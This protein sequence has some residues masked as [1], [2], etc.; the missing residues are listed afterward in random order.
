[1]KWCVMAAALMLATG[2]S[3][4]DLSPFFPILITQTSEA[5][6]TPPGQYN[7]IAKPSELARS[8][9]SDVT[10]LS[11]SPPGSNTIS[12]EIVAKNYFSKFRHQK[13]DGD[14][15]SVELLVSTKRAPLSYYQH[16]DGRKT[17]W[18]YPLST[19]VPEGIKTKPNGLDQATFLVRIKNLT[20]GKDMHIKVI[21]SLGVTGVRPPNADDNT[22]ID[23]GPTRRIGVAN[24]VD[25][26]AVWS[27]SIE[28]FTLFSNASHPNLVS[29][30]VGDI[31][32]RTHPL[33]PL[34]GLLLGCRLEVELPH[35]T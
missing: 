17:G 18:T 14:S 10:L 5:Q 33:F 24:Q 35:F 1:M 11:C 21:N 7:Y 23:C 3:C 20:T 12:P 19:E 34:C 29:A 4:A 16:P 27:R 31:A 2:G 8:T 9:K 6:V 28:L 13:L 15:T 25:N 26:F 22:E 32:D 30:A